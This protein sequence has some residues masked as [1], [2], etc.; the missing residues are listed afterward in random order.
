[1]WGRGTGVVFLI[2]GFGLSPQAFAGEMPS[3]RT[4]GQGCPTPASGVEG[5]ANQVGAQFEAAAAAG[6]T[7]AKTPL[8]RELQLPRMLTQDFYLP[9]DLCADAKANNPGKRFALVAGKAHVCDK[10]SKIC[11]KTL[12]DF[13]DT[14]NRFLQDNFALYHT[15][16][17]RLVRGD[18]ALAKTQ[19]GADEISEKWEKGGG[20]DLSV[21]QLD[22]C[23]VFPMTGP[24]IDSADHYQ[25]P[26]P[27]RFRLMQEQI[28]RVPGVREAMGDAANYKPGDT[29]KNCVLQPDTTVDQAWDA[30]EKQSQE[31][32]KAKGKPIWED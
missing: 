29:E 19:V 23:K 12:R 13:A 25:S 30:L 3:E 7:D 31:M 5:A 4:T 9:K 1:M 10:G 32:E 21:I 15:R 18:P 16:G 28:L 6:R 26:A 11:L 17:Y 8:K 22:T 2:L 27:E 24:G 14:C 20:P